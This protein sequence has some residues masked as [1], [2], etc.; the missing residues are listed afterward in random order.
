MYGI[1]ICLSLCVSN[2]FDILRSPPPCLFCWCMLATHYNCYAA[3]IAYCDSRLGVEAVDVTCRHHWRTAD[4]RQRKWHK[5]S[6]MPRVNC[7]GLAFI[8]CVKQQSPL[9]VV[10]NGYTHVTAALLQVKF[11]IFVA[12]ESA[13][14]TAASFYVN[15]RSMGN[16]DLQIKSVWCCCS[17][18]YTSGERLLIFLCQIFRIV[19][20]K[21]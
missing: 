10:T 6:Q 3:E 17:K 2:V 11:A 18:R 13:N 9:V 1:F 16:I 7:S 15:S 20:W 19:Y 5:H 8:Y 4:T 21:V 12:G 14:I